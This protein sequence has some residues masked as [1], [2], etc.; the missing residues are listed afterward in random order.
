MGGLLHEL[1][2]SNLRQTIY[3]FKEETLQCP[4][5]KTQNKRFQQEPCNY[6]RGAQGH[7][8]TH[9]HANISSEIQTSG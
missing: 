6:G 7:I 1:A 3:G 4:M 2:A 8:L 5:A 9:G